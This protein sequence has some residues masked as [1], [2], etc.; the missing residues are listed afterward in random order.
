MPPAKLLDQVRAAARLRH[1]SLRTEEAY[2]NWIKRYILFHGKRHPAEMGADE[3]RAF[4]THLAVEG[5]VAAATQNVAL[6]ALLFLYRGVLKV[7]LGH[8]EEIERA[9][10]PHKLPV[11]FSRAEVAAVLGRLTGEQRLVARLLYGAGLRLME[12][13]RLRVKD[14]DFEAARLVVRDGKGEKD[15]VT[16]L[17]QALHEE[18]RLQLARARRRHEGDLAEGFGEVFL[19]YALARK[20][21]NAAADWR[22]Q[23]VFPSA[24]RSAD[25]RSGQVRRHHLSAESVQRAV[26]AA[27][28]AAGLTKAG[29]CHTFRHSF[30]TH[31]LEDNYDIRTIQQ[32]LGHSDVRTTMIYTHVAGRGVLGVRSPLDPR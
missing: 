22:W 14:V 11:V 8:V 25:P 2:V 16:L 17:P 31:L 29:S 26:A 20:Y 21:P 18:L 7:E 5:R 32:L 24:R 6:C 23:Y 3:V 12:A 4:L 19:P 9:R 13:L 28:R 30:A 27:V 10:G 1:L 15:R